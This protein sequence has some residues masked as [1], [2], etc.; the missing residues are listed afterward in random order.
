MRVRWIV[1][2]PENRSFIYLVLIIWKC[3]VGCYS[4]YF[5]LQL[6]VCI[7]ANN[8]LAC[9]LL[10]ATTHWWGELI[11]FASFMWKNGTSINFGIWHD[12]WI[13]TSTI[14][15]IPHIINKWD[16]K[17]PNLMHRSLCGSDYLVL[18]TSGILFMFEKL[19]T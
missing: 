12:M 11:L 16:D 6:E 15:C 10:V 2:V 7:G 3:M 4:T 18:E 14:S 17:I 5:S 13:F 19:K 1:S 8:W 9:D